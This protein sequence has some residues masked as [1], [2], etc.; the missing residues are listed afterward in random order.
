MGFACRPWTGHWLVLS[1]QGRKISCRKCRHAAL[2]DCGGAGIAATDNVYRGPGQDT[3]PRVLPEPVL[4]V[5]ARPIPNPLQQPRIHALV[6]EFIFLWSRACAAIA[7]WWR[8]QG[9]ALAVG[10]DHTAGHGSRLFTGESSMPWRRWCLIIANQN[11][12]GSESYLPL[13]RLGRASLQTTGP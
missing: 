3:A 5:L 8:G 9:R 4:G 13:S 6:R 7:T 1:V 10:L 12:S 11:P 2:F